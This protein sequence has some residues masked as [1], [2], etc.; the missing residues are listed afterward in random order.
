MFGFIK[1]MFC[2]DTLE[3]RKAKAVK[4]DKKVREAMTS[5]DMDRNVMSSMHNSDPITKY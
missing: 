1:N 4:Q 3:R 5:K 2:E